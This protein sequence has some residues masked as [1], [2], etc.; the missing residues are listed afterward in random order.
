MTNKDAF[1]SQYV[2]CFKNGLRAS[3]A[4]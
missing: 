3:I 4:P 1:S 2:A